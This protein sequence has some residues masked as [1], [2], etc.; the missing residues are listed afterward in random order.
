MNNLTK[1]FGIIA[2]AG[3]ALP[4]VAAICIPQVPVVTYG[5]VRDEYGTPMTKAQAAELALVK[6]AERGG[7]VYAQCAVGES[8]IPGM[9][10]RLTQELDSATGGRKNAVTVGTRMFI[11][12]TVGGVEQALA[13]DTAFATPKQGTMRRVD[14][15]TGADV[16]GDG[17]PD[18]WERWVLML[19]GR[20]ATDEEVAAF[21]P[22]DDADGDG[23]SNLR[24][25]LAGTDP[26][27]ATDI[28]KISSFERVPGTDRAKI[29]FTT[30]FGRKFRVVMTE[31]LDQPLWSPIGM[32]DTVD[33]EP[34]YD[35]YEG[36]GFEREVYID[37]RMSSAF[38]RIAVN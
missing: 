36:D 11:R 7:R 30:A 14:Y 10:F 12:A 15:T 25:Y 3:L 22:D 4:A 18:A 34:N 16:D 2:A 5:I 31:K 37:A 26:F 23:M 8:S 6:D 17:M 13:P 27:L 21:R 28:I 20:D 35:V 38:V 24:E 33:G 1:T 19:D 32:S 9:N 29:T